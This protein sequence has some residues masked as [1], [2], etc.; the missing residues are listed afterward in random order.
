MDAC[1]VESEVGKVNPIT[2]AGLSKGVVSAPPDG[3]STHRWLS[4]QGGFQL[5]VRNEASPANEL[6]KHPLHMCPRLRDFTEALT[7]FRLESGSPSLLTSCS[8]RCW[9]SIRVTQSGRLN[10]SGKDSVPHTATAKSR[11][12]SSVCFRWDLQSCCGVS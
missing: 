11:G 5:R 8:M 3:L 12:R 9:T 4:K 6:A 10:L 2:M 7:A 1:W